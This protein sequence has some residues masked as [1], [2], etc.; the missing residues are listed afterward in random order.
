MLNI[1]EVPLN[2][3][4]FAPEDYGMLFTD[5]YAVTLNGVAARVRVTRESALPFN[6]PW[7]GTQ[8][9]G[10]QSELA[11]F[12]SFS[13]DEPIQVVVSGDFQAEQAVLRPLSCGLAPASHGVGQV[14]FTL[15]K[16]GYYVLELT[17]AHNVLY[18]LFDKPTEAVDENSVV[19]YFGPGLH[20]PG[21][22]RL[23]SG[24]SVYIDPSA[25]VFGT[26]Y[27]NDVHNVR[28]FGGGTLHGGMVERFFRRLNEDIQPSSVKFYNSTD[29]HISDIIVQDSPGWTTMFFGCSDIRIDHYKVLGQWRYNTD[30]IDFV[31]TDHAEVTD[32]FVRAFDD[33][34][35]LKGYD[36]APLASVP[37][38]MGRAVS[39]IAVRNCVLW[40]GWGRTLE[41]GIETGAPEFMRILFENCDL[42]HNS[43]VC[44]DIQNGNYADIHDVTFRDLRIEY[45]ADNLPEVFQESDAQVYRRDN[46]WLFRQ[47]D[48]PDGKG[49]I[50]LGVPRL[51]FADNHRWGFPGKYGSIRDILYENIAVVTEP[52]VPNRLPVRIASLDDE[53]VFRNFTI[54]NLTVNGKRI[55]GPEDVEY[56]TEGHVENVIWE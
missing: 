18:F 32:S 6:R 30:G 56:D 39:D 54:R 29:I 48:S 50:A 28:I 11:G 53:A 31:N 44:L 17:S 47:I 45:Q 13:A 7:P 1:H 10:S 41:I 24:D 52:G 34:I 3:K 20:F 36:H 55:T 14:E 42:I 2:R 33:A 12:V 23:N 5:R 16:P 9:P 22:I 35:V 38:R 51:L 27:G 25:I 43:A 21:E 19:R 49:K 26:I 15:A 8:R 46:S 40:C 37:W 4:A